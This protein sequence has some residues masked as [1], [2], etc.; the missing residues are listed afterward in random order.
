MILKH[1]DK[2]WVL[3]K[4]FTQS[5]GIDYK[6]NFYPMSQKDCLQI[7]VP[8]VAHFDFELHQ[9]VCEYDFP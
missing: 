7:L 4:G 6:E 2:P 1:F 8:L 3:A 9:N 5:E